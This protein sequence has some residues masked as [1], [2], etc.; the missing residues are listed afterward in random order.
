MNVEGKQPSLEVI[1]SLTATFHQDFVVL[2]V[3]GVKSTDSLVWEQCL[4][5][6]RKG[7]GLF[8]MQHNE[9]FDLVGVLVRPWQGHAR[10]PTRT[11]K[12]IAMKNRPI[13]FFVSYL[14][15]SFDKLGIL[16]YI[17]FFYDS[18]W[19][20][21]FCQ[22]SIIQSKCLVLYVIV[23]LSLKFLKILKSFW[24]SIISTWR[25]KST[26]QNNNTTISFSLMLL[27]S[28][29]SLCYI[30]KSYRYL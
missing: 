14:I 22:N 18:S 23:T 21:V 1:G 10:T 15:P 11:R 7:I 20:C 13:P 9:K 28:I 3:L 17:E 4:S 26:L 8:L 29:V 19:Q 12:D 16:P 27:S 25:R 6:Q 5:W 2:N 24:E 30:R